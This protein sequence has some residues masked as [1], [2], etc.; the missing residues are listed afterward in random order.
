MTVEFSLEGLRQTTAGSPGG[1]YLRGTWLPFAARTELTDSDPIL[2]VRL[3]GEGLVAF[4][5]TGGGLALMQERCPHNGYSLV[6]SSVEDKSLVCWKHGWHFGTDGACWVEGYQGKTWPVQWANA[7]SYPAKAWGGLLWS[8][9][10]ANPLVFSPPAI[11][12][13]LAGIETVALSGVQEIN[14][15]DSLAFGVS[16]GQELMAP[17]HTARP[18]MLML[19]LPVDDEHTW[20][21]AVGRPGEQDAALAHIKLAA[22]DV[23]SNALTPAKARVVEYVRDALRE[24]ARPS[25]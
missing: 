12:A 11:P 25:P 19:R 16:E 3:L 13:D 7:T 17:C 22:Y 15:L 9:L 18:G 24:T 23:S 4:R 10:G 1:D 8:Y 5:T 6:G 20:V 21:L 14:W 2:P